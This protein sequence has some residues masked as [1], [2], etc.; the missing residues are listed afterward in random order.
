VPKEV[1][2]LARTHTKAAIDKLAVWMRSDDPRASGAA[3]NSLLDRGY[4]K[5]VAPIELDNHRSEFDHLSDEQLKA[6]LIKNVAAFGIPIDV[7][8]RA[9]G[10]PIE[11]DGE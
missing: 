9:I 1:R 2:E 6:E 10:G 11:G 3:C 7:V 5:P 8:E 4:G